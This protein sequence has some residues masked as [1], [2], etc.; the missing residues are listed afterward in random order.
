MDSFYVGYDNGHWL[1][2][3]RLETLKGEQRDRVG[4]PPNA[5]FGV[6]VTSPG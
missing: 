3:Q 6:T 1:Q 4:G 2:V 5:A